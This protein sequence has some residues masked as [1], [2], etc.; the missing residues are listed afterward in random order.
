MLFLSSFSCLKQLFLLKHSAF[1]ETCRD[2]TVLHYLRKAS[3]DLRLSLPTVAKSKFPGSNISDPQAY[4]TFFPPS[5]HLTNH[6]A[7]CG[8]GFCVR[9]YLQL[10]KSLCNSLHFPSLSH[11]SL[12]HQQ[13]LPLRCSPMRY[14]FTWIKSSNVRL[15]NFC[16]ISYN[17][18]TPIQNE[19]TSSLQSGSPPTH[20][21]FSENSSKRNA[22]VSVVV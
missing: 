17:E 9:Y 22:D 4:P 10:L 15:I 2:I 16:N 18:N 11:R 1:S 14:M 5:R 12:H 8:G 19:E 3:N 6:W 7:T 20:T 13:T 21:V